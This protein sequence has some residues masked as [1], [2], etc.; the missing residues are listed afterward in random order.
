MKF[1]LNFLNLLIICLISSLMTRKTSFRRDGEETDKRDWG[2]TE[3][4]GK[5]IANAFILPKELRLVCYLIH[6]KKNRYKIKQRL[7]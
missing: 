1:L 4:F 2:K 5:S 6:G 3:T 7:Y